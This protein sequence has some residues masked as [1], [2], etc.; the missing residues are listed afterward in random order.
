MNGRL[1]AMVVDDERLARKRLC[2]LLQAHA[3]IEVVAEADG[4]E[5]AHAAAESLRPDLLFL[6]V[7]LSPGSG[8][9]L[10]R[11]LSYRPAT[12]FVTAFESSAVQAFD[13]C[14]FDYLLKPINPARLALSIERLVARGSVA[15]E[16][17]RALEPLGLGG[18]ITLKDA[19]Q[20]R[21]VE[22]ARIVAIKAEGAYS[23]VLLRDAAPMTVLRGIS[24][25]ERLLPE[26]S[27]ARLDRSVLVQVSL[28]RG[29]E[30]ISRDEAW[31]TFEGISL[32]LGVGRSALLRLRRYIAG[33]SARSASPFAKAARSAGAGR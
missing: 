33:P 20:V 4:L 31:L 24:E 28:V 32:R 18:R 8:F 23:R 5:T 2:D 22:V 15:K 6:D 29:I 9:E 3:M 14:A 30:T 27:F 12:I 21:V 7:E 1:R 19:G 11:R 16:E 26:N 10:L 13:V 25:W 17:A